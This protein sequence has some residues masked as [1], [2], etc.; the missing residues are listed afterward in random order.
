MNLLFAI[1]II[2]VILA[3]FVALK[4]KKPA[5]NPPLAFER[6]EYL[7]SPAER[8]FLGVLEQSLDNRYRVL[9]KVRLGDIV[10][11]AKDP[12]RSNQITALNKIRQKHVDFIIC[13][14]SDLAV[15]GVVELDDK[16]HDRK[17]RAGRDNFVD[18]VLAS[19]KIP[20][21]HFPA[22]KGYELQDVRLQLAEAFRTNVDLVAMPVAVEPMSVQ[23]GVVEAVEMVESP[24]ET[25][26]VC[27][28][29]AAV[30]VKKQAKNGPH[31]GKWFWACPAFPKCR[32]VLEIG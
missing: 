29:C 17:D 4:F 9:G 6:C 21:L 18:L 32:H 12:S 3:L 23:P 30:M 1:A 24:I 5:Q 31:A 27:P 28:K 7:F 19:A 11:P 10:K 8:S 20:V 22:R 26:P 13:S 2:T 15:V 16:S 25:A 14:A